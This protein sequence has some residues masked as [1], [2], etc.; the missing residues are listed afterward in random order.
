MTISTETSETSLT[1]HDGLRLHVEQRAVAGSARGV[2]V[3]VHG[4]TMHAACYR[5]VSTALVAANLNVM[6]FDCRG[7]GRSEGRRGYVKHFADFEADLRAVVELGRRTWPDLPVAVMAHSQGG[8]IALSTALAAPLPV[9][10]MVLAAPWLGLAMPIPLAKRALAPVMLRLW[11]TLA[12]AN[13][14]RVEDVTRDKAMQDKLAVDPLIHHVATARW[15]S[16]A[17]AAQRRIFERAATLT[18]PTFIAVP[19][20]DRIADA[21]TTMAFAKA[22]GT[23]VQTH[24]Y[25]DAYHEL[26]LEP[27]HEQIVADIVSWLVPR[28]NARIL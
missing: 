2:V 26:F 8:A 19:G 5:H 10:A 6:A 18:I 27:E 14:I 24:T 1:T 4:F 20:D 17:Q 22:A 3:F 21:T 12:L 9:A 23:I 16:Q 28:L 15:F 7:H 25:P 11:P 13:G